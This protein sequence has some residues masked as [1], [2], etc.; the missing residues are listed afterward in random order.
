LIAIIP[1]FPKEK[2]SY[3]QDRR[4]SHKKKSTWLFSVLFF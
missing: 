3:P 4:F 2:N 1:F